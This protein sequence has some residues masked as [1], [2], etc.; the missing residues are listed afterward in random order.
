[1]SEAVL[2][3]AR[4]VR[5][6]RIACCDEEAV[7]PVGVIATRPDRAPLFRLTPR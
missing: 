5:A 1:M 6:S 3:L 4:L 7:W 2:V